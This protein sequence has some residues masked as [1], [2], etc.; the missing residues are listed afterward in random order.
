[1][2]TFKFE[3]KTQ[4]VKNLNQ[5]DIKIIKTDMRT[6]EK[7]ERISNNEFVNKIL[8]ETNKQRHNEYQQKSKSKKTKRY[9]QNKKIR[10]LRGHNH[11]TMVSDH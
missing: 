11:F 3:K 2:P 5:S 1:M 10:Q 8:L 7:Q 9:F 6:K 4:K